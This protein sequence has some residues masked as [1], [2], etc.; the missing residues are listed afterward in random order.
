MSVT[1]VKRKNATRPPTYHVRW[2]KGKYEPYVYLGS[3]DT[4]AR[5][6]A[7]RHKCL[8][9]LAIGIEPTLEMFKH[10]KPAGPAKGL[11]DWSQEWMDAQVQ[12]EPTT[13]SKRESYV[14]LTLDYFGASVDPLKFTPADVRQYIAAMTEAKLK[15]STQHTRLTCLSQILDFAGHKDNPVR[16]R[17]VKKVKN[18]SARRPMP[19]V[20][21][22]A[23]I[24]AEL[25]E[26]DRE[27]FDVLEHTG[28][29][30]SEATT[31][32]WDYVDQRARRL[33][34][35]GGTKSFERVI[36]VLDGQPDWLP[37]K[38]EGARPDDNVFNISSPT[39]GV[40][41]KAASDRA[42]DFH[43]NPNQLRHVHASRLLAGGQ[44]GG[45]ET[46]MGPA[47]MAYRM[48]HTVKVF[49]STY[50]HRIPPEA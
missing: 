43:L 41:L 10:S 1:I 34:G 38:R 26:E 47:D 46:G 35:R 17:A 36:P 4:K 7:R 30:V 2:V 25:P 20:A 49:L 48:G 45:L 22:L 50:T 21:Q 42:G 32:T 13:R 5:A 14:K 28:M 31:M 16:D 8:D 6:E 3:L 9:L 24:R 40:H 37:V 44:G 12:W 19:T 33:V 39:F 18:K 23:A 29:R 15:G 11:G 27:L